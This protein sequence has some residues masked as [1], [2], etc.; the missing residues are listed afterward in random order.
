M[1]ER[2]LFDDNGDIRNVIPTL[3]NE[4]QPPELPAIK[5]AT[6][7]M[8]ASK[9]ADSPANN[10]ASSSDDKKTIFAIN[11]DVRHLGDILESMADLDQEIMESEGVITP[12]VEALLAQDEHDLENK[13]DGYGSIIHEYEGKLSIIDTEIKRLN[14]LKSLYSNTKENII[15]VVDFQMKRFDL[16][17]LRGKTTRI[18]YRSSASVDYDIVKLTEPFDKDII[19]LKEKVPNYINIEINVS[20]KE[21]NAVLKC[22]PETIPDGGAAI[23]NKKNIQI[24]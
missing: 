4:K 12:T 19:A 22:Q 15:R 8:T 11:N 13:I 7:R 5:P 2:T 1:P 6:K 24:K 14:K 18:S 16:K 10:P 3:I 21:L 20:K 23:I 17:E 9:P